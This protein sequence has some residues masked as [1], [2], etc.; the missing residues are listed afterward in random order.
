MQNNLVRVTLAIFLSLTF[1]L[2][3]AQDGWTKEYDKKGIVMLTSD[4]PGIKAFKGIM[5]VDAPIHACI[6]LLQDVKHQP[7]YLHSVKTAKT[8]SIKSEK[9]SYLYYTLDL[10]FP[11]KD[12]DIYT[13]A[14]FVVKQDGAVE[15]QMKSEPTAY[16]ETKCVRMEVA[17][18]YWRFE[19]VSTNKTK[20]V[21]EF[22]SDPKGISAW[23]VNKFLTDG[24]VETLSNF[25]S[26]VSK[27]EYANKSVAWL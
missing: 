24:P 23:M 10:P 16:P 21:Y 8:V 13:R 6:N 18:G 17:D 7:E 20:I 5:T 9:D 19:P 2:L 22:K 27:G 11:Y 26:W 3:Q 15:C 25:R 1:G 4:G 14:T 12:R